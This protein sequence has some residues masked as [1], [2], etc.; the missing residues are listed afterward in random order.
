LQV[1]EFEKDVCTEV[2][3]ERL[4]PDQVGTFDIPCYTLGGVSGCG[5][6]FL[7]DVIQLSA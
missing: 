1:F 7:D 5:R 2:I 4:R 6:R 3:A